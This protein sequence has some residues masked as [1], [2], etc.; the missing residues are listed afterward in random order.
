[1]GVGTK[2]LMAGS[3]ALKPQAERVKGELSVVASTARL[4]LHHREGPTFES[5]VPGYQAALD[6]HEA[7]QRRYPGDA[8]VE[9]A[10]N[11]AFEPPAPRSPWVWDLHRHCD[12]VVSPC[13]RPFLPL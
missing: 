6:S 9:A 2:Y 11:P 4:L 8:L 3:Q 12:P 13:E 5:V 10:T 7:V 1:M